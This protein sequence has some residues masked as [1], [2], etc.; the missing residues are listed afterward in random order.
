MF[1]GSDSMFVGVALGVAVLGAC[2]GSFL[3]VVVWRLQQEDRSKRTLGGRS[4]CPKCGAAIR[5]FDNVP[6]LSW[7]LLRG[8]GRCCGGRIAFRYPLI[9]LLTAGLFV[10]LFVWPPEPF[11]HAI[12]VDGRDLTV[13]QESAAAFGLRS[14]FVS[15]LVA[16]SFIDFDTQLLPDVLTKP[17][18]GIGLI[19]GFWPGIAGVITDDTSAP[20]ALRTVLASVI[21]MLV[22]GGATW[23]IRAVGSRVFRREAMGFGDV[24]LMMMIGAWLGWESAL[25]T[26]FLGCVVG[27]VIG[28]AGALLGRGTVIPFGPFLAIGAVIALFA[29]DPILTFLFTTW[30]E[31]QQNSSTA[32]W[33]LA[34]FAAVALVLLFV[35]VRLGRRR[36]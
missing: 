27:A 34:V 16:L 12:A 4:H 7:L 10:A 21:G 18:I 23:L 28:G 33:V 5:W 2:V 31:L 22:G 9:E 13:D 6:V 25:L 15:L 30:P 8:K 32:P 3:N 29:R 36:T 26:I 24:K 17:G 1:A 20:L 19:G 14:V 11:G 35:L